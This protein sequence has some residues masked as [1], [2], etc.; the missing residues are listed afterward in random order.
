MNKNHLSYFVFFITAFQSMNILLG[1]SY[2]LKVCP[3]IQ[4]RLVHRALPQTTVYQLIKGTYPCSLN[5]PR[6]Y[7]HKDCFWFLLFQMLLQSIAPGI[8]ATVLLFIFN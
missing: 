2:D 6:S 4:F 7:G 8:Q 1:L 5:H 3:V